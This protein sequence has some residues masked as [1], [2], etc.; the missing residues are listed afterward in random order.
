[1]LRL[2]VAVEVPEPWASRVQGYRCA[3]GDDAAGVPTHITLV[4]PTDLDDRPGVVESVVATLTEAATGCPP[5]S[6]R[7]RG[8]DSF[9]PVSP[10]AYV[11]VADGA[12]CLGRLASS[13]RTGPLD[14]PAAFPFHPHVTLAHGVA[15]ADLDRAV[16]DHADV[17]LR[18]TVEAMTLYRHD[19]AA[20]EPWRRFP[21][22][23]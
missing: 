14:S 12:G 19:G 10:V 13:S 23:G 15:E 7:L 4:P 22:T 21:L 8:S 9:R 20:W 3:L 1:M 11:V 16:A 6:V 18:F 5:F 2:G 17:D